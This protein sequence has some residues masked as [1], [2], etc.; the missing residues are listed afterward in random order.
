[1]S[2]SA[3]IQQGAPLEALADHLDGLAH[4][5]RVRAIRGVGGKGQRRLW[6]LAEG[7]A[8]QM[9]AIVPADRP[10]L[11]QVRH[12]GKNS[13]PMFSHFEKRFCRPVEGAT[14]WWG[15]NHQPNAWVTGP[16]YFICKPSTEPERGAVVVDYHHVPPTDHPLPEGWPAVKPNDRGLSKPVYGFMEDYLRRVS[17]HVTIGRAWRHGKETQNHFILCREP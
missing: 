12:F 1:M 2:F 11:A 16:G 8:A 6:A 4:D 17:V 14:E 13:L 9:D 10:P 7:N 5:G 3:L 15:Y